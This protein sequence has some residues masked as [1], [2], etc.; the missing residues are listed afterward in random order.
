MGEVQAL[1]NARVVGENRDGYL[2]EVEIPIDSAYRAYAESVV[3]E[4]NVDRTQLYLD[5]A[6][7]QDKPLEI[8][9]RDYA[10]QWVERAYPGE[11]VQGG[12]GKWMKK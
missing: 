3:K 10:R 8:I 5:Y 12:D 7:Q 6:R 2:E 11:Y 9:E 4:E 1:K